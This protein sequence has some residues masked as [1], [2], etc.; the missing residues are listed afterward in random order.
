MVVSPG[1]PQKHEQTGQGGTAPPEAMMVLLGLE[2]LVVP[3][4][5]AATKVHQAGQVIYPKAPLSDL[6]MKF[7]S[8]YPTS[9]HA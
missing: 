4:H 5:T 9:E 3:T 7:P 8:T 6:H 2:I 1:D